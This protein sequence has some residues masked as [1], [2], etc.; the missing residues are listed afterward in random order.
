M[1]LTERLRGLYQMVRALRALNRLL[2]TMTALLILVAACEG[3]SDPSGGAKALLRVEN[4]SD[5]SAW[6]LRIRACDTEGWGGDLLES[7]TI[8]VGNSRTLGMAPGCVDIKTET[9]PALSGRKAW[10][11]L[12]LSPGGIDTVRLDGWVYA[13]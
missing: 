4:A 5:H 13:P 6:Y 12:E 10:T 1:T 9:D 8:A 2:A 11:G 7:E 3:P